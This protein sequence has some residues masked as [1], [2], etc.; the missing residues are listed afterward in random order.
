MTFKYNIDIPLDAPER[1]LVH[2]EIILSK[3]FL[4]R[5]YLEWY[6]TFSREADK[7]PDGDI[8]ELGSGGGFLK[9]LIPAIITSD[10]LPLPTNDVTF[11]ALDMPFA[12]NSISGLFMVDTFHHIPDAHLF[13][14]EASRVLKTGG[15]LI[16][17]EPANSAWGRFIYTHFHHEPFNPAGDWKIPDQGPLSG[18]N[19][20]LPW[21]VFVRDKKLFEQKF[22]GLE[23]EQITFHTPLR[24]LL[25]GGVS[26]KSF[27]PG[28]SYA[29][30]RRIDSLLVLLSKQLS[31][32][33][34]I[35][36]RKTGDRNPE[37][38]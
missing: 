23:I 26:Y 12:G 29:L 7:L 31:M 6:E 14:L 5:L 9:E 8:V 28:F 36:I 16:M 38:R 10:I 18:A 27:V 19:G 32:F 24:Y 33:M 15:K 4:K 35:T 21:I 3:L 25:S 11:S 34:T 20:S 13:L 22:P 17:I 30:F 37:V 1:T 2:K